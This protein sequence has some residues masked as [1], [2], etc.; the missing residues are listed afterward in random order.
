MPLSDILNCATGDV[1]RI[2]DSDESYDKKHWFLCKG[3]SIIEL[4]K[5]GEMLDVDSYDNLTAGFRLVGEL[6]DEGPWPQTIPEALTKRLRVIT[7]DEITAVV[8]LWA[9]VDELRGAATIE[10]L[11]GYLKRLRSYLSER[12]G[13][14]FLVDAL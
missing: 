8:P 2:L 13:E 4:S 7:D 12:S 9:E 14:F 6:R 10:S 3:I 1:W 5:L 11:T